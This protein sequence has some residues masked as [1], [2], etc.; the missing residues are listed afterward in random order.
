[1]HKGVRKHS[2]SESALIYE[3]AQ[4]DFC[5]QVCTAV[6]QLDGLYL[7]PITL[8]SF[9][10][11]KTCIFCSGSVCEILLL[12]YMSMEPP[13]V[14]EQAPQQGAD[15]TL[16]YDSILK[17]KTSAHFGLAVWSGS[18]TSKT[19]ALRFHNKTCTHVLGIVIRGLGLGKG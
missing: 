11:F 4:C 7:S 18:V 16:S 9:W 17:L 8:A 15:I 19:G 10:C 14:K 12:T 3:P 13:V 6:A 5:C 1:M 2:S